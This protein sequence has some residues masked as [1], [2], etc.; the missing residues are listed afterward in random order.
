MLEFS[1][2]ECIIIDCGYRS[3]YENELRPLLRKLQKKGCRVA[4][5]IV[6]HTDRDHI[7][8]AIAFLKENGQ[9]GNPKVI[10]VEHIWF[11]GFFH[12]LFRRSEFEERKKILSARQEQIQKRVMSDL[13]LQMPGEEGSI[14]A[15]QSLSFEELCIRNGYHLNVHFPDGE[16][17]RNGQSREEILRNALFIGGCR[18]A[19]LSPGEEELD[20]LAEKMNLE[21]IRNFG[22]G[23]GIVQDSRY[24]KLLELLMEKEM[25]SSFHEEGISARSDTLESW[26]GTSRQTPVNEIN[27]ASLVAEIRYGGIRMLFTGDSDSSIWK[28]YLRD[29]YDVIKLP[30]HGTAHPCKALLENTRGEKILISTNGGPGG[31]HPEEETVAQVILAGNRK[32]YFNYEIRQKDKL[33]KLQEQY[34]YQVFFNKREIEV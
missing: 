21:M 10:P 16:A 12:T 29:A 31:R 15:S 23:Y 6:T 18:I 17:K 27:K 26:M 9:S 20:K 11:N 4:L 33:E 13:M 5:L 32:L 25:E 7:E 1:N 34:G 22:V 2:Q 28:S 30:H 14:S 24:M 3:T 8:G 19:V